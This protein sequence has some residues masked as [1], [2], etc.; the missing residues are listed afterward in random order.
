MKHLLLYTESDRHCDDERKT[1]KKEITDREIRGELFLCRIFSVKSAQNLR[2]FWRTTP[3]LFI[4]ALLS[5][6]YG[7]RTF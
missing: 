6:L 3:N 4:L 2:T 1:T 5:S 7:Q